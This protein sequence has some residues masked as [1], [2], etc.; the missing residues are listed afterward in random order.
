MIN[1][2]KFNEIFRTTDHTRRVEKERRIAHYRAEADKALEEALIESYRATGMHPCVINVDFLVSDLED[3]IR[4]KVSD[5][6]VKGFKKWLEQEILR[7]G[8]FN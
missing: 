7:T 8:D 1:K 6:A 5:S 2:K 3:E 4:V